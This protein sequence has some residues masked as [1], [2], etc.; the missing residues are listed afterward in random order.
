MIILSPMKSFQWAFATVAA[1]L[2]PMYGV[3]QE[4]VVSGVVY[5]DANGNGI[6]DG[7]EKGVPGAKVTLLSF[8][9]EEELQSLVSGPD[10]EYSFDVVP[11]GEYQLQIT[12]PSG[13]TVITDPFVLAAGLDGPFLAIPIVNGVSIQRFS[14][15]TLV[16]PANVRGREVSPFS[17]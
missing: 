4:G 3:A 13:L 14:N 10:G 6:M 2:L 15:L 16:N 17:P 12:F 5:E 1:I 7:G 9:D 8:P 11:P